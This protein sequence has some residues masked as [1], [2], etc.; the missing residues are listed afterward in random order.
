LWIREANVYLVHDTP[1]LNGCTGIAADAL[2][3]RQTKRNK[4]PLK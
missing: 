1:N 2:L 3:Y 4:S